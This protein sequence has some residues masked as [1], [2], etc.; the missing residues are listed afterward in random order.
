M[1]VVVRSRNLVVRPSL[2]AAVQRKLDRFEHVARDAARADVHLSEERN[3]RISDRYICTVTLHLRHGVVTGRG[4]AAEPT[5]A[6]DVVLEKLR[7]QVERLKD[8]R[9]RRAHDGRRAVR[10]ARTRS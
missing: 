9:V 8:Q 1:Q 4:A 2:R 5:T 7:H 6:V 10:R 3:P